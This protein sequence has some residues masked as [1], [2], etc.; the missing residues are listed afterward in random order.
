MKKAMI[1]GMVA[2]CVAGGAIAQDGVVMVDP[3]GGS[4]ASEAEVSVEAALVSSHVWRGQVRNNDFVFQPQ[5]T[6]KQYGVSFNVW[7]NYDMGKSF[8]GTQSDFSEIDLA[9]A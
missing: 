1:F 3:M 6:I 7:A 4:D 2:V 9:L 5:A 8:N